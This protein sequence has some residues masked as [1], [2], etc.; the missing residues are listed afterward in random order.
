MWSV[1]DRPFTAM[2]FMAW[3][4]SRIV[5]GAVIADLWQTARTIDENPN[6]DKIGEE[7]LSDRAPRRA[8]VEPI[9]PP[10]FMK[11][12]AGHNIR[13]AAEQARH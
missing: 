2:R 3:K 10:R 11:F 1:S 6:V 8:G 12:V 7:S 5:D 4:K 9:A 13:D